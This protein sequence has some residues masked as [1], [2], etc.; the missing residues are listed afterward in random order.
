M[1]SLVEIK[2]PN[3]I[4]IHY[5]YDEADHEA[6]SDRGDSIDSVDHTGDSV[7]IN[8]C[9]VSPR[10][11]TS[12]EVAVQVNLSEDGEK[13]ETENKAVATKGKIIIYYPFDCKYLVFI[14]KLDLKYLRLSSEP[15]C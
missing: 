9:A 12:T 1:C 8:N 10:G 7:T 15:L 4:Y 5:M 13:R 2:N 6:T 14:C 3:E 11:V